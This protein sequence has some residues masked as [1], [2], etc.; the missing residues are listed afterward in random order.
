MIWMPG[1]QAKPP[2]GSPD[3]ATRPAPGLERA[4]H[5]DSLG[6]FGLALASAPTKITDRL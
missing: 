2:E 4:N 5:A 1:E 6:A 3:E